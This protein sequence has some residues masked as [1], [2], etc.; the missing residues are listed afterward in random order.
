MVEL[1]ERGVEGALGG[2]RADV[3][4]VDHR[5]GELPAGPGVRPA[6]RTPCGRTCATARARR[7]G[8]RRDRGS[9]SD[10]VVVVEEVAVVDVAV[11][12]RRCRPATTSRPRS[13]SSRPA[14]RRPTAAPARARGAQTSNGPAAHPSSLRQQGDGIGR[15]QVCRGAPGCRPV[16]TRRPSRD[17]VDASSPSGSS[18]VVSPQ[19][20]PRARPT[21]SRVTTVIA[22][23]R[24]NASTWSAAGPVA[25]RPA[26]VVN[27]SGRSR[28]RRS[29]RWVTSS[30]AAPGSSGT[31]VSGRRRRRGRA[32]Q[33]GARVEVDEPAVVGVDQALLPQLAALVDVGDAGHRERDQL[34]G[35]RV[36]PAGCRPRARAARRA[37]AR[38]SASSK[39]AS[40]AACTASS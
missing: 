9:G 38:T 7:A 20:P 19:P 4:L 18:S 8:W 21:G 22:P 28:R 11:R 13:A 15:Q 30:L 25:V 1:A 27:S 35:Q 32:E 10:A 6:T 2:E 34:G 26:Y 24:S 3:Q 23:P 37:T 31:S 5:A 17:H 33:L 29:A 36:G 12:G 16:E 14:R 40:T 39:A